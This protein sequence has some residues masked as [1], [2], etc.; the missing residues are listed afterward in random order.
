MNSRRLFL[1]LF[2]SFIFAGQLAAGPISRQEAMNNAQAFLA[3][4][5]KAFSLN[6]IRR[7]P[8]QQTVSDDQPYYLFN[9]G[10]N[11]GYVIAA[12]DDRVPAILGYSDKGTL[13]PDSLPANMKAWLAQ[14]ERQIRYMQENDLQPT[15]LT[16]TTHATIAPL[17]ST[18]WDQTDPYNQSCPDFLTTG[19]K[20][21]TGC[22]AT[23]MAQVMYHHRNSSVTKTTKTI[24]AYTCRTKW[25]TSNGTQQVEVEAVPAGSVI[26]WNNI[27]NSYSGSETAVQ[28]KAVADL[29]FYCGASV[30]MN[31]ADQYNGGSGAF[32]SDIP[33]ALTGYF[34]YS[35]NTQLA[36]RSDYT[37][38]DWDNLIYNELA[39]NR[40]VLYT[41]VTDS[42]G[43]HAFV[44][45]GYDGNGYYHINWGWG[46][47]CDAN[48]LLSNLLPE[49]Q[50]TGGSD[51]A[52]N[53]SQVALIGAEP[54]GG[55]TPTPPVEDN[56]SF[57]DSNV[58]AICVNN[59]D[60]NGDGELSETEAAAVTSLGTVFKGNTNIRTFNELSYFTGLTST[61]SSAFYGCTALTSVT[62][63]VNLTIIGS[64][65]F[66]NCYALTSLTIPSSVTNISVNAFS[67][68]RSLSSIKV[69]SGNT[70]YD[71]RNNCN[72]I[73][74]TS[75]NTLVV[76]C[77]N[78]VIPSTVTALEGYAFRG[79]TGL[80][81][82][83]I[84]S[85]VSS[86]GNYTFY[87]CAALT[88]VT[89]ENPTPVTIYSNT[90]SNRANATLFVPSGAKS[91]YEAAD[92]WTEFKGIVEVGTAPGTI[93]LSSTYFPD[94]NFRAKISS[95]T[96]V[97]EGGTLTE[98]ILQ[99][100]TIINFSGS[101]QSVG[102]IASLNGI[103]F[104]TALIE[105]SCFDNQLTSLDVSK[106]TALTSLNCSGNPLT[107][108]DVSKNTALTNLICDYNQLTSLDVSKNTALTDLSCFC[109][110]LTSLDVSKNTALTSLNCSS[111]QLTSLDVSKNTALTSLGCYNNHLTSLDVSKNTV[112]TCLECGGNQLTSLDVSKNTALTWLD[113]NWNHLT[114]LD[115]SKN[116]ALERL[117]C[118]DN[119]LMC[120][121][122]SKCSRLDL[123]FTFISN[124]SISLSA[125]KRGTNQY[126][127]S[128]PEGFSNSKVSEFKVDDTSVTPIQVNHELT[129][130]SAS[131]PQVVT[132]KYDSGNSAAGKMNVTVTIS[133]IEDTTGVV[134]NATNFPDDAFRSKISSITGVAE[135]G[136]LT[137]DILQSVKTINVSGLYVGN[138]GNVSTLQGIEYFTALTK[139][140]CSY[141]KLT[142]LD[143]SKNTALTSLICSNNQLTVLDISKNIALTELSCMDNQL[144]ALDVS[145]NTALKKIYSTNNQLTTLNVSQNTDLTGLYCAHNPLQVLDV[146]KN[147][148]LTRLDCYSG[149]L[150]SL[151]VS[152]NVLLTELH[153]GGNQLSKLDVSKNVALAK[154]SCYNNK[155]TSLDVS[156]NTA[157]TSLNC[158]SNNL[159]ALDV[160]KNT[161]LTELSCY[162]N[163]LTTLDVTKNTALTDFSCGSNQLMCLDASQ[164]S[165][166][167][168]SK[169][170]ISSQSI[171]L[172]ANKIG[173]NL[174]QIAV[175]EGFILSKVSEFKV[176]G[177]S[178]TPSLLNGMLTFTSTTT[179]LYITYKY[180][181]GS[182]VAG[183]MN[184]SVG[185][186][187]IEDMS[188]VIL[189]DT[190]FPDATFRAKVSSIT[191]VAEGGTLTDEILQS[192]T[193]I[194]VSGS[195][196]SVGTIASLKGIEFFTALT[197]LYC[198]YNQ[199]TSL[200]VSKNTAL[201]SLICD[202]NQLTS[203]DVSKNTALTY[204]Y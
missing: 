88:S 58:K 10:S 131:T 181:S 187:E 78:T 141:N 91:A 62:L 114:S 95:I 146:S 190:N 20:A 89:V 40:P 69:A 12:G 189:N 70:T 169:T 177:T 49:D 25:N 17:L 123:S 98:E 113:C 11:E 9:I 46:G 34:D 14:Y 161:L 136:T 203:L 1:L 65:A 137:E 53:N 74:K 110:Q 21:V 143:V 163:A 162:S 119:Q 35:S 107:S 106:N 63:P 200:D 121:D 133:K 75:T 66:Y 180:D 52:Y 126:W 157:L 68:C 51:G 183:K 167:I 144:A 145:K 72:A 97:A 176:G 85:G 54:N 120:L 15:V 96:G 156:K 201:T 41:G 178:V 152:K 87:Q 151:D 26:D 149:N 125:T 198:G 8:S 27:L 6:S 38:A 170:S 130:T 159:T 116:T 103:E 194:N 108:L 23:A 31:Y 109:N 173:T 111:N 184:V 175:P 101:S 134:L 104:F 122:A 129:F 44:C 83:T 77:K 185:I 3:K 32:N 37:E 73:I 135:G 13:L 56:I 124:Q 188:G 117:F 199:L 5:G 102:T 57:A 186:S 76:G 140:N 59:W 60:T 42:G 71:S 118:Y 28:K 93:T 179:P 29:M 2:L 90:F 112:L 150:T 165:R 153:C 154:L 43:G 105:L 164:C 202:N 39:N 195:S 16:A 132:Y 48:F 168:S 80:T 84:P 160:S 94:A 82:I 86:I 61:G 172:T 100:V 50:G 92:Y 158:S 142:A 99:S 147:T 4:R 204:L 191:G 22:V 64:T 45:D 36:K 33:P 193:K 127:I 67:G 19:R 55:S 138:D 196:S 192:V 128:V 174:Y 148:A 139:L 30:K 47:Y 81:S 115:V 171:T 79:C 182:S 166:L 7:V 18:T 24:P 197:Y 155:Q